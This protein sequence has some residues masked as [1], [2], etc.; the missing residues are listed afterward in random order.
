MTLDLSTF[1]GLRNAL[2][3]AQ[4]TFEQDDIA[5]DVAA[6]QETLIFPVIPQDESRGNA[7]VVHELVQLQN[8]L[9]HI[10]KGISDSTEI[11]YNR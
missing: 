5:D 9:K 11:E 2:A 3:S 7:G 6:E 8:T 10:S 1:P 4:T